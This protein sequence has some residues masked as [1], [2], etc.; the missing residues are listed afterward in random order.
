MSKSQ[1]KKKLSIV[2]AIQGVFFIALFLYSILKG[3]I[4]SYILLILPITVIIVI[5]LHETG[6]LIL[7]KMFHYKLVEFKASFLT[8]EKVNRRFRFSLKHGFIDG[9]CRMVPTEKSLKSHNGIIFMMLGGVCMNFITGVCFILSGIMIE[10]SLH[11]KIFSYLLGIFSLLSVFM[12]VYPYLSNGEPNDGLTVWK[13]IKSK[14]YASKVQ[15]HQSI[16]LQLD[17]GYRVKDLVLPIHCSKNIDHLDIYFLMLAYYK[18]VEKAGLGRGSI[19]IKEIEDTLDLHPVLKKEIYVYEIIVFHLINQ[20]QELAQK[21]ID[22]VALLNDESHDTNPMTLR[23]KAYL[24]WYIHENKEKALE[25]IENASSINTELFYF[26]ERKLEQLFINEL[27]D[28]IELSSMNEE[29]ISQMK[30]NSF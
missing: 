29:I 14:S 24:S 19:I 22:H 21:Y 20:Q 16:M 9:A 12:N 8:W 1:S 5:L 10:F 11:L 17:K 26:G 27:K 15:Y 2:E 4:L 30:E 23:V 13:V 25:Y 18:E 6:H 3:S 7:G 28:R